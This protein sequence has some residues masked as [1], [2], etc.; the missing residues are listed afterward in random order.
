MSELERAK[1]IQLIK[2]ISDNATKMTYEEINLSEPVLLQVQQF[3]D[4]Q[5]KSG[6]LSAMGL[7]IALV[8]GIPREAIKKMAFTDYKACEVY[9]M[10]FLSYSPPVSGG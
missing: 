3:Y 8:S 2:S 10:S 1:T 7:L 5:T 9:L 4:E 6:S